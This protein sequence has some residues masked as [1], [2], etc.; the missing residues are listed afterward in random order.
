[1]GASS[2]RSRVAA[3]SSRRRRSPAWMQSATRRTRPLRRPHD[4]PPQ[5]PRPLLRR[6]Q[7]RPEHHAA[8]PRPSPPNG[9]APREHAPLDAPEAAPRAG[10]AR[11]RGGARRGGGGAGGDCVEGA[12]MKPRR[13]NA[14]SVNFDDGT[15]WPRVEL[16][17]AELNHLL[18]YGEP[19]R[20]DLLA[21]ASVLGAY[22][23]LVH[24]TQRRR[25]EVC[26]ALQAVER[27]ASQRIN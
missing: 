4:P 9:E 23:A 22:D 27:E 5:R 25:N 21:A 8:P 6:W 3:R 10:V 7:R 19:T 20:S 13:I 24:S 2:I 14:A 12:P 11:P 1:A 15:N 16:A 26:A 18:R 17:L